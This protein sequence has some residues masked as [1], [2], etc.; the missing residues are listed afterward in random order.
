MCDCDSPLGVEDAIEGGG[1]PVGAWQGEDCPQVVEG[2]VSLGERTHQP[3]LLE[4]GPLLLQGPGAPQITL[5]GETHKSQ[6]G[7]RSQERWHNASVEGKIS[8][9][10]L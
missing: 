5:R 7:D 9:L 4:G 10:A 1:A 3:G 2:D 8:S 6:S